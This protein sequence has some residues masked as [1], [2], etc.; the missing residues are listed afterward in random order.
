MFW[1]IL[2]TSVDCERAFL[3]AGLIHTDRRNGLAE[4]TSAVLM[5]VG[6]WSKAGSVKTEGSLDKGTGRMWRLWR[7]V[8]AVLR[9]WKSI[10][11]AG[12]AGMV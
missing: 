11:G 1:D 9:L 5:V 10:N 8:R 4:D 7:R 2:A 3:V 6:A 12:T